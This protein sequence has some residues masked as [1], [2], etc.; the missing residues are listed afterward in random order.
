MA[1]TA[2]TEPDDRSMPP[3]MITCVTP[4]AI[5]PTIETCRTM[6]SR[7]CGIAQEGLPADASSRAPRRAARC[8][9]ARAGCRVRSGAGAARPCVRPRRSSWSVVPSCVVS[10]PVAGAF[11]APFADPARPV[12]SRQHPSR[13]GS[14]GTLPAGM[15][16]ARPWLTPPPICMME[17]WSASARSRIPVIR[18]SCMTRMRS[19]MPSTSGISDEIMIT[20]TPWPARREIK[21]W[22]SALA[23]TSMPRVGSSRIRIFGPVISQRPISTFCWLPPDR[24]SIR[25]SRSGS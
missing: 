16:P 18:P 25:S 2:S 10:R 12:S 7:R 17:T 9:S 4:I 22:I 8:R 13:L 5:T 21:R 6:T 1:E 20:A 15:R 14:R 19:L 3:V 24:F 11:T 23:P